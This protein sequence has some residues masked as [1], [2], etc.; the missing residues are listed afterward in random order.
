MVPLTV[1]YLPYLHLD[2]KE[3][4]LT[5]RYCP[6]G[7]LTVRYLSTISLL[8]L[9]VIYLKLYLRK[10]K[11]NKNGKSF[12]DEGG[13]DRGWMYRGRGRGERGTEGLMMLCKM[14]IMIDGWMR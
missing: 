13:R 8:D 5:V 11:V 9:K 3:D 4:T 7:P 6:Y 1:R 10:F 2:H 12:P 14:A